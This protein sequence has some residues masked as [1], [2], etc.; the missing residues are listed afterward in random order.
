M[1]TLV[2][3]SHSKQITDGI[4]ALIQEMVPDED[5][6]FEVLSAGGTD[7]GKIGTSPMRIMEVINQ[8][9]GDQIYI[10]TDMG[11]AVLSSESALDFL[12]ES[13]HEKIT[14]LETPIVESAYIAAVQC[15][16][17]ADKETLLQAI[18]GQA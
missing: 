15:S 16:I 5:Q 18:K 7:D 9:Q 14:I 10:F 3:V 17:G 8:A 4:A 13:L 11:S 12:D 6:T 2:L 1:Q